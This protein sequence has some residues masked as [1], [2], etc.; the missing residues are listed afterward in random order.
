MNTIRIVP[1]GT[2][3]NSGGQY[4][5]FTYSGPTLPS[6]ITNN[7]ILTSRTRYSFSFVDPATT[8]GSL[9]IVVT[10]GRSGLTW[11]GGVAGSE[12]AWN[13][14]TTSNWNNGGVPDYF[15]NGDAVLF[16]DTAVTN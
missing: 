14:N 3:N 16:D 12:T 1:I 6:S 10:G 13:V 15:F 4:T 8:P 7:F 2:L 9:Q 5:L 11:Q